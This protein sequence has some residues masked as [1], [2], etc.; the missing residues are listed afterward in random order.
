MR[1]TVKLD[2]RKI[3]FVDCVSMCLGRITITD[4]LSPSDCPRPRTPQQKWRD[5]PHSCNEYSLLSP[6]NDRFR[7]CLV[8]AQRQCR[9]VLSIT[10]L[11][12]QLEQGIDLTSWATKVSEFRYYPEF[13][14]LLSVLPTVRYLPCL[15]C[16][17]FPLEA[18]TRAPSQLRSSS[19]PPPYL[20]T[21]CPPVGHN[22]CRG[23]LARMARP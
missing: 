1:W 6:Q 8:Y 12:M 21:F 11:P 19:V 10:Q 4:S 5:M 9:V 16:A 22:A 2:W 15:N 14:L 23:E 13:N 18:K 20:E 7:H 3:P 17:N